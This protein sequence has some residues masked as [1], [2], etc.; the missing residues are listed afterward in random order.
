[1]LSGS[2]T[3]LPTEG[4]RDL[5]NLLM[6]NSAEQTV[7][8]IVE[9]LFEDILNQVKQVLL[10]WAGLTQMASFIV[11]QRATRRMGDCGREGEGSVIFRL[12]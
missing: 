5:S 6:V 9:L 1:M 4:R 10:V 8:S 3:R 2:S 11:G 12:N 7:E